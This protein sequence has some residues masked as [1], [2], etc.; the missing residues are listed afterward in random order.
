MMWKAISKEAKMVEVSELAA[1]AMG[2]SLRASSVEA[3]KGFRLT[4]GEEGFT[5]EIDNPTEKDQ[6]IKHEET[7]VLIVDQGVEEE[8]GNVVIDVEEGQEGPQ[9]MMRSG[10]SKNN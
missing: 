8:V 7:I 3:D 10:S 1:M 5:L 6:V 9:L 4:K 2:Q